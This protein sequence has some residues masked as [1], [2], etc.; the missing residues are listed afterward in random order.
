MTLRTSTS[1]QYEAGISTLQ[2]RQRQLVEAQ[3]RLSSGKRIM[4][5]SDDP[6]GAARAERALAAEK[7]SEANQRA[8]DAA[9]NAMTGA[10]AAL[11][12]AG[13][14]LQSAREV[15][16]AAGNATLTDAARASLAQ[17]LRG[18]RQQLLG[19]ANRSDG[20]GG[21]LFA[22][23]GASA[24][25]FVDAPGGVRFNGVSGQT[26]VSSGEP[27]PITADGGA[28]WLQAPT[29]NGVFETR[30]VQQNGSA[31]IDS[32]RVTN[33]SALTNSS[34]EVR[35]SA[36]A[37]GPEYTLYQ[38]GNATAAAGV[39]YQSGKAIE[40][41]GMAVTLTGTPANGDRF[42]VLPSQPTL[43]V[44][45]VLDSAIATLSTPSQNSGTL[46]QAVSQGLRDLDASAGRIQTSRSGAGEALRRIDRVAD[47]EDALK[48]AAQ[49]D[50][51]QAEDLDMVQALSEFQSKQSGYEAALKTYA[52]VQRLSLFQYIGS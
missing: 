25:P 18:L 5:A 38:D 33:P 15:V 10:E 16:V 42:N 8:V 23:Q 47:R 20:A 49:T 7:R 46:T 27:L 17:E 41:G 32:G 31:W 19:V 2:T 14:L 44:F 36:G 26:M 40:F 37:S 52:S 11:G 45:T 43:N 1:A 51:S 50:R 35:F 6:T 24:P 48:L 4:Q 9:R 34:W 28:T 22:G 39:P 3:E 21:Y 30:A 13:E 29:G 12:D